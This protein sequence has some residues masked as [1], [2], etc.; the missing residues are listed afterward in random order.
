MAQKIFEIVARIMGVP[1]EAVNIESSPETLVN[2]D[3]LRHIKLLLAV[4]ES[5]GIRFSDDDLVSIKNVRDLLARLEVR[6]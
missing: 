3:S 4:E 2:W 5:V 6:K 1:V